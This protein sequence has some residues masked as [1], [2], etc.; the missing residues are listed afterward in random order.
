MYLFAL[1]A[2]EGGESNKFVDFMLREVDLGAGF[3]PACWVLLLAI[4]V[5]AALIVVISI[6]ASRLVKKGKRVYAPKDETIDVSGAEA[7]RFRKRK[8]KLPRLRRIR[9]RR[10]IIFQRHSMNLS[11]NP[12]RKKSRRKYLPLKRQSRKKKK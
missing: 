11:V 12:N 4:V 6:V 7:L 8:R 10:Q 3:K 1:A 5:L 9:S 2:T